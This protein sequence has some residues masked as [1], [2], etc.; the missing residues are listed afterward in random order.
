M[1]IRVNDDIVKKADSLSD[2]RWEWQVDAQEG[3]IVVFGVTDSK[4]QR[5]YSA[6]TTVSSW[7]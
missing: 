1:S 6:P 5:I 7:A 4:G 3:D 2:Y